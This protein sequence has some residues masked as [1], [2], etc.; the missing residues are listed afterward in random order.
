MTI[1]VVSHPAICNAAEVTAHT[2]TQQLFAA[3]RPVDFSGKDLSFLDLAGLSNGLQTIA[4]G[5]RRDGLRS[6]HH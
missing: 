2:V 6:R 5:R 4:D 1:L 3:T